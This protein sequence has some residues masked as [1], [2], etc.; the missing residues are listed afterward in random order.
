[1]RTFYCYL[2]QRGRPF[3]CRV[4]WPDNRHAWCGGCNR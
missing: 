2:R 4:L 1:M 3:S